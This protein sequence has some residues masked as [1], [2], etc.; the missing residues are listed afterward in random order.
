MIVAEGLPGFD[1][2]LT[3]SSETARSVA[4]WPRSA[5]TAT[6]DR[7]SGGIVVALAVLAALAVGGAVWMARSD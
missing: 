7:Y 4:G 2:D 3:I 6:V 5:A 1:F